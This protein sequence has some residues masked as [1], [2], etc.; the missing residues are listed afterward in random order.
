MIVFDLQ[1][2]AHH[3]FE[4][5]FAGEDDFQQQRQRAILLCPLCGDSSVSKRLSAPRLNL[6]AQSHSELSASSASD[7]KVDDIE[8]VL[9]RA[10]LDAARK[11]IADTEDVGSNFSREAR[12]IHYGETPGRGIRGYATATE[13]ASLIDEGIEV[14]PLVMP[15]GSKN[16]LQ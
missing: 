12:R 11:V 16:T 13:T 1:C 2:S 5:W 3:V 14:M 8:K 6:A 7:V 10:W 15:D 4:G 9:Q